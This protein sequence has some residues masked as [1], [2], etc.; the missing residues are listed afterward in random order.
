M[1]LIIFY[2]GVCLLC[3]KLINFLSRYPEN[4]LIYFSPLQSPYAQKELD[5]KYHLQNTV[6]VKYDNELYNKSE[7]VFLI[8]KI[9]KHPLRFAKYLL[10]NV[11]WNWGYDLIA[12]KRYLWFGKKEQCIFP[13]D[14]P[15]FLIDEQLN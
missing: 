14:N 3:S 13:K 10:P 9:I 1:R 7:A 6:F 11:I 15:Q 5:Q 8:L 2:D 12:R 4:S